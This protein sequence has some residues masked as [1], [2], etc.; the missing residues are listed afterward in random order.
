MNG[1]DSVV[2]NRMGHAQLQL[3]HHYY[4]QPTAASVKG[5]LMNNHS[6][7]PRRAFPP[8]PSLLNE[9][10]QMNGLDSVVCN[11]M[12]AMRSRSHTLLLRPAK[13]AAP[14][15]KVRAFDE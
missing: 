15:V 14:S 2:C 6:C 3:Q 9:G 5:A 11:R 1:L 13:T 4:V 8:F 12:G 10:H 7:C